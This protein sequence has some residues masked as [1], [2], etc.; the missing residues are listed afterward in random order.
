MLGGRA[1]APPAAAVQEWARRSDIRPRITLTFGKPLP[2]CCSLDLQAVEV[3][4]PEYANIRGRPSADQE[5]FCEPLRSQRP[6][7]QEFE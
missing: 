7:G 1:L 2:H 4:L 3:C 5:I 6:L